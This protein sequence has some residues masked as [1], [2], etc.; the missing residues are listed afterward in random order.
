MFFENGRV[1]YYEIFTLPQLKVWSWLTSKV[2]GVSF[3]YSQWCMDPK[4]CLKT[5]KK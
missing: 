3:T 1:D 2:K 4:A 5:I